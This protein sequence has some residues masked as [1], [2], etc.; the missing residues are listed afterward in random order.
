VEIARGSLTNR[1][2]GCVLADFATRRL[3]GELTVGGPSDKPVRVVLHNGAIVAAASPLAS[4]S[5]ARVGMTINIITSTQVAELTRRVA[6]APD[7]D[8]VEVIAEFL[9]LAPELAHRLRRRVIALR[10]ARTFATETASY[11]LDDRIQLP[12]INGAAVDT[13]AV[14]FLGARTHLTSEQLARDVH[15]LGNGVSFTPELIAELSQFGLGEAEAPIVDAL[16]AGR[17]LAALLANRTDGERRLVHAVVYALAA[18]SQHDHAG[19]LDARELTD[20]LSVAFR[21]RP[22]SLPPGTRGTGPAS[23]PPATTPPLPPVIQATPRMSI[24]PATTLRTPSAAASP[25]RAASRSDAEGRSS[26][27]ASPGRAASGSDAEGRSIAAASPGRAASGSD[28]EGRS[29]AAASPGRAASRSDAEGRSIAPATTPREPTAPVLRSTPTPTLQPSLPRTTTPTPTQTTPPFPRA[30][31]KPSSPPLDAPAPPATSGTKPP[32]ITA[33]ATPMLSRTATPVRPTP[34]PGRTA[35]TTASQLIAR[36]TGRY[37][38][39]AEATGSQPGIENAA[40]GD[41]DRRAEKTPTS[42]PANVPATAP[43]ERARADAADARRRG[44]MAMRREQLPA[45]LE[46]FAKA[47]QL[48]PKNGAYAALLAWTQFCVASDKAAVATETRRVLDRACQDTEE[49]IARL[50]LGKVERMLGRDKE[51]LRHFRRVLEQHPH[52]NEAQSEARVL[53]GRL[54]N[55]SSS[56]FGKPKR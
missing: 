5:A 19:E 24:A 43:V 40:E 8:E 56:G 29:I 2:W 49:P 37:P 35:A 48:D 31:T 53:E 18:W 3:T 11:A 39:V 21:K 10:A 15:V 32:P 28:A 47:A 4:D 9:H 33:E 34:V 51:A 23:I 36:A 42:P 52:N 16:R 38:A 27:A 44:E 6:A 25:G 17:P 20:T 1:V 45:A 26:A 50:Y 55:R 46:E 12:V 41:A 54:A 30:G 22:T 14:V 7:R 13:R